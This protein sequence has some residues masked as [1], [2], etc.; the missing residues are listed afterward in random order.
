LNFEQLP[1][2]HLNYLVR[3]LGL[4]KDDEEKM[5]QRVRS[6]TIANRNTVMAALEQKWPGTKTRLLEEWAI[7]SGLTLTLWRA[8]ALDHLKTDAELQKAAAAGLKTPLP[9]G[10]WVT[11]K[12]PK[13]AEP[14]AKVDADGNPVVPAPRVVQAKKVPG[15]L[16]VRVR[17]AKKIVWDDEEGNPERDI[18]SRIVEVV[19]K[20]KAVDGVPVMLVKVFTGYNDA[21]KAVRAAV[22]WL[23]GANIPQTGPRVKDFFELV[24]FHH[25]DV[26]SLVKQLNMEHVVADC[27][28]AEG[29]ASRIRIEGHEVAGDIAAL[30][31]KHPLVAE[32]AS[33]VQDKPTYAYTYAHPAD[34][35]PERVNVTFVLKGNPHLEFP[36][37]TSKLAIEQ[38]IAD[39]EAVVGLKP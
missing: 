8:K 34:G 24:P 13:Q 38:L 12:R 6:T 16:H 14:Q 39:L 2:K 4:K 9:A 23:S 11:G 36:T 3:K 10:Q 35:F 33:M 17:I 19:L 32:I 22:V 29:R 31:V 5:L 15:E 26:D 20:P 1:Q 7:R 30:D 18:R 25:G 28:D 27:I 21:N 37:R